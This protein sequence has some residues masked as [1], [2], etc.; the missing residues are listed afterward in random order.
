MSLISVSG[1]ADT[2]FRQNKVNYRRQIINGFMRLLFKALDLYC[3]ES[4]NVKLHW[5][6]KLWSY[7]HNLHIIRTDVSMRSEDIVEFCRIRSY[8]I[9]IR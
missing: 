6:S 9:Q 5:I 1:L 3:P 4:R 2:G 7:G 8:R